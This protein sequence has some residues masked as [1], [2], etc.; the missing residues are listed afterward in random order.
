M[1]GS[2]VVPFGDRARV[3]QTLKIFDE[4]TTLDPLPVFSATASGDFVETIAD[5]FEQ[6]CRC[7][8]IGESVVWYAHGVHLVPLLRG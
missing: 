1:S 6:F 3:T 8:T 7:R 2:F 5:V 4:P